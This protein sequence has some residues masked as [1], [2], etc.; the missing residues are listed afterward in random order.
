MSQPQSSDDSQVAT[1]EHHRGYSCSHPAGWIWKPSQSGFKKPWFSVRSIH[2]DTHLVGGL[3]NDFYSSIQ[4]GSSSSQLT[5]SIIFQ[6]GRSTI[7][8]SC[9]GIQYSGWDLCWMMTVNSTMKIDVSP[10][11]VFFFGGD[12]AHDLVQLW[13][14]LCQL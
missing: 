9:W 7:N 8:Q 12:C 4:L 2:C 3:E 13:P 14:E 5:N 6:R 10:S 11:T 1:L